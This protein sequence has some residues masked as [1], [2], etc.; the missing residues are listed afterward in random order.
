MHFQDRDE[1]PHVDPAD[2]Q[3]NIYVYI[4]A[5]CIVLQRS[6]APAD[7]RLLSPRDRRGT[8]RE[9][10]RERR[11]CVVSPSIGVLRKSEKTFS[12]RASAASIW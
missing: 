9:R 2:V 5:Y 4:C 10:E 3:T 8:Q 7:G 11:V 1:K 6:D 12:P